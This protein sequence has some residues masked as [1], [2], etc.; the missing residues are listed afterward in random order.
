MGQAG[1]SQRHLLLL[2]LLAALNFV[3]RASAQWATLHHSL[4]Y[5]ISEL[6][7]LLVVILGSLGLPNDGCLLWCILN[8]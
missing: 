2:L 1:D 4:T 3:F 7:N 5:R 8:D 6:L